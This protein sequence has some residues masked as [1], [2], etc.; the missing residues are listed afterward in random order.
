[1]K[2]FCC[3][4]LRRRA[5]KHHAT[6]NGIAYL[7][8]LDDPNLSDDQRQRTL[9]VHF[10]KE[11][12]VGAL[13][14]GNVRIEGGRRIRNVAVVDAAVIDPLVL[15]VK[16]DQAGDFSTY[17]LR[18]VVDAENLYPPDGFDAILSTVDF[19]FKAGCFSEFDCRQTRV[20][21]PVPLPLP[22]IDYLAKDYASFRR[23]M[24]NRMALL[25]PQWKER[26]PADM[27]VA[28]VELLAY[29]GDYLSY[30]QDA[31]ATEA[32]LDTARRRVSVRRHARLVD[33][34]M[35]D[36]SNARV[37]VQVQ[38]SG[39]HVMLASKTRLLTLVAGLAD[40]IP[41]GALDKALDLTPEVFETLQD[42]VLYN[43]HNNISFY[44]WGE[45]RCCLPKGATRATLSDAANNRLRLRPGDVLI[46]EER[47]DPDTGREEDADPAHRHAVRLTH[48]S[49]K[50][51]VAE[52]GSRTPGE[53]LSDELFQQH[54][55]E[56]EWGVEDAL[57]FPLCI[58]ATSNSGDDQQVSVALGN[59]VL[60]DH[61]LTM[62]LDPPGPEVIGTVPEPTLFTPQPPA[63]DRC[64]TSSDAPLWPRFRPHLKKGPLT[65][66]VPLPFSDESPGHFKPAA[67]AMQYTPRDALPEIVLHTGPQ[68]WHPQRDLLNSGPRDRH[69]VVE[70]ASDETAGLRFGDGRFGMRPDAGLTF[71]AVYRVGNGTRGNV[72]AGA[73][74]H[75]V[76]DDGTIEKVRNPIPARGGVGPEN[77]E[78]VRQR[79]PSAF[80]T[81]ERAVTPEDYAEM[82]AH[83][84]EVQKASA[85]FRWTGSWYTVFV[86]AD[87]IGGL[88]VDE[89]FEGKM[90]GHIERYRMAG[91]DLEIDAPRY[92]P[93]EI[94]MGVCVKPEYFRSDVKS[95][96]LDV[97]S[98]G[99]RPDGQRGIFHPDNF[100]FGQ[101]VYLSHI[102]HAAM[103]VNGVASVEVTKFQR[104]NAL[105]EE[106]LHS[107][108]L[109]L[110]RIEIARL[111]NDPDFPENGVLRIHLEG[112]K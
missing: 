90:R 109:A 45:K 8:V 111:D 104:W 24:L 1:M 15:A 4:S 46:F 53:L 102:Y 35:H 92:V 38:V 79:A 87:R 31:V 105:D 64:M 70:V 2:Y 41:T 33:Y 84:P 50:A 59:I 108:A 95:A 99:V 28:L 13:A 52:D 112:G 34:F 20:C 19:S 54:V 12:G 71:T 18:L 6:L 63:V 75:I 97:F 32:Y 73:I 25:L 93:L 77:M 60:A 106:A 48:V 40:R 69:F 101:A 10:I 80:R 82:A 81:Q 58:S 26:N 86:T 11:L 47:I 98:N 29:V 66:A 37:W 9:Y 56:I 42:A 49:P 85:T 100:S 57:P 43:A 67:A 103:A 17:T 68:K 21:P 62:D 36:G 96:L 88:P 76:S 44:T 65:Q 23:L 39:D 7:E 72:G 16:L 83:N 110:G 55:V 107:G 91:H 74:V 61:G 3:D 27:G 78:D 30:Q 14:G 89:A 5:V 94:D 51:A 22:D